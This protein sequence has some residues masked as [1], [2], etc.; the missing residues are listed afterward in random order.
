M[1]HTTLLTAAF[2]LGLAACASNPPA[3][4]HAAA[5]ATGPLTFSKS[6]APPPDRLEGLSYSAEE[7][8]RMGACNALGVNAF[9]IA[10][11]KQGGAKLEDVRQ[12]YAGSDVSKYTLPIVEKVYKDTV[13]NAW[14]YA[15]DYFTGCA[16]EAAQ[17]SQARAVPA[18]FCFLNTLIGADAIASRS[19]GAAEADVLRK[20]VALQSDVPKVIVESVYALPEVPQHG[21]GMQIWDTCMAPIPETPAAGN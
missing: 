5:P 21:A 17:V 13:T 8:S 20:Y 16:Q 4:T 14:D 3:A 12:H 9:A 18:R 2:C 19:H 6:I 7:K 15:L 11:A 10:M 1:R